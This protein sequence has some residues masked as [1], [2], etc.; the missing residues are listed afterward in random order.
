MNVDL[1]FKWD[2]G[3]FTIGKNHLNW[4]YA[5]NGKIVLSEKAPS[6]PYV[7]LDIKPTDWLTFNYIHAWLNSDVV[8]TNSLYSTWRVSEVLFS[9]PLYLYFKVYGN[10]LGYVQ[11]P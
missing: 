2:W 6:F 1:G 4:G 10:A 8:D 11:F 3:S 7:R 5:E 9:K